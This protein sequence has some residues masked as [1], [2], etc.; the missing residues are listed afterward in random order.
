M[1]RFKRPS[2]TCPH[3]RTAGRVRFKAALLAVALI[4]GGS[5]PARAGLLVG[6]AD[7]TVAPGSGSFDITL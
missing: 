7:L 5:V 2:S 3:L 1:R 6:I 4:A